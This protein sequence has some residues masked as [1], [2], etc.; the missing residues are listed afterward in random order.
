MGSGDAHDH[1]AEIAAVG[2]N[3]LM[4]EPQE[5]GAFYEVK[6]RDPDGQIF[7]INEGGWKTR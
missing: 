5:E 6:Y 1:D 3:W 2:G 4:V 7:D